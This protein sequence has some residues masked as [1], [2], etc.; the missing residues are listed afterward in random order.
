MY[1]LCGAFGKSICIKFNSQ[2]FT[3]M[4]NKQT[5]N[6]VAQTRNENANAASKQQVKNNGK[7]TPAPKSDAPVGTPVPANL[8][9]IQSLRLFSAHSDA[10]GALAPVGKRDQAVHT[11]RQ[12]RFSAAGGPD[13]QYLLPFPD[14][15]VDVVQRRLR[16][17]IV[18]KAEIMKR[19]DR[20]VHGLH[21]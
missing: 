19:D 9:E 16:L 10:A 6:T 4:A 20:F 18:L 3:I 21:L 2:N 15:K 7:N 12:R 8:E 13:D 11:V 14:L 1:Y 17:R 5:R